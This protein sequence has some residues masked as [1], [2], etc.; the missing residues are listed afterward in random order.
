[1][2]IGEI[3]KIKDEELYNKLMEM[4]FDYSQ[5]IKRKCKNCK[6]RK[7]CFKDK[8]NHRTK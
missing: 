6:K 1:M 5:C 7:E 2:K 4:A 8:G 3:I